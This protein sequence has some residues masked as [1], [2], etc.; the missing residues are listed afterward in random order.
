MTEVNSDAFPS[1][2]REL[3]QKDENVL[4]GDAPPATALTDISPDIL[5]DVTWSTRKSELYAID[6]YFREGCWIF[7]EDIPGMLGVAL[8]MLKPEA[9]VGRRLRPALDALSAAGFK[10]LDVIRFR[11][12]RLSIRE[13]YRYQFNR[14]SPDLIAAMDLVLPST[15]SVCLILRDEH[16]VPGAPPA[17]VRLNSLKGPSDMALRRPQHLRYQ[18]GVV[19]GLLNFIHVSDELIDVV[20][21]IAVLCDVERQ[22]LTRERIR[23]DFDAVS[24]TLSVFDDL[25]LMHPAHDFDHDAS[26]LRLAGTDGLVGRLARQRAEGMRIPLGQLIP[27]AREASLQGSLDWDLL[28]VLTCALE[29]MT[30]PGITPT[31]P[32]ITT[33]WV[34]SV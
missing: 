20:R 16:W 27:A 10:P 21:E 22:V 18:L 25:E 32:T 11:Y 28:T 1:V 33:D 4:L 23:S 19:N 26:W 17:S 24:E 34:D 30:I 5:L 8:C 2:P 12:D 14:A 15:D 31:V 13:V 6:S 29:V 3:S 7:A 9:V